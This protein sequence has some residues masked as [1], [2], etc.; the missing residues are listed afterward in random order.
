MTAVGTCKELA[1]FSKTD[2]VCELVRG[3]NGTQWTKIQSCDLPCGWGARKHFCC[4]FKSDTSLRV[5]W[6]NVLQ[7]PSNLALRLRVPGPDQ[8]RTIQVRTCMG[9]EFCAVTLLAV[10]MAPRAVVPMS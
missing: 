4:F 2:S 7:Q 10:N 8:K 3:P 6:I 5:Y 9:T 1:F